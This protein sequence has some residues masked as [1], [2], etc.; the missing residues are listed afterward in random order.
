MDMTWIISLLVFMMVLLCSMGAYLVLGS[1]A[2]MNVIKRRAGG[3]L[4]VG[5]SDHE[6]LGLTFKDKLHS[7]LTRLGEANKP[8][9]ES[10]V[11]AI[12]EELATAGYRHAQA[13]ILFMGAKLLSSILALGLAILLPAKLLG[14]PTMAV[15]LVIYVAAASVGYLLPMLWLRH[16]VS[17]RKEKIQDAFPDAL[18]LMVVCV[19][20]GL[21]LD[22]A[23]SR[24]SSEI[25]FAHPELAEEFNLVSLELRTGLSRAEA[26]KNLKRRIDLEEVSSLVALLVQTDKFGT[27]IG[28]SLRVHSDS[29]RVNRQ[30]RAEEVAAKLPVK[31][32]FPLVFFIFPSLFVVVIG[33]GAVKI[34]RV[35][36]PVLAGQ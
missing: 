7:L 23:I 14:F 5:S 13:P 20:A 1:R 16:A 6:S 35:L 31:L 15:Q 21:G 19:E 29:M 26:L 8:S 24:V 22:A 28:Q 17:Q 27:S 12:R 25:R 30:L 34:A 11:S 4:G 2:T 18:D 3:Q 10:E 36:M 9:K 33:P 32:L